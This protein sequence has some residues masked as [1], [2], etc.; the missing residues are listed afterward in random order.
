MVTTF[1]HGCPINPMFWPGLS[2][3]VEI[4]PL[5]GSPFDEDIDK[6]LEDLSSHPSKLIDELLNNSLSISVACH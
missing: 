1:T 2:H 6:D 4:K 3:E 5:D